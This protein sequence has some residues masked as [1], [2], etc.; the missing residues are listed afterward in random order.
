MFHIWFTKIF[1]VFRGKYLSWLTLLSASHCFAKLGCT[2]QDCLMKS[3]FWFGML[4]LAGCTAPR[5]MSFPY[6]PSGRGLNSTAAEMTPAIAGRYIVFTSDRQGRQDIYLYDTVNRGLL[7][8]PGLNALDMSEANPAISENGRY[9][10]FE[11]TRDGR[12]GIYLYDR[13]VRQLRNLTEAIKAQ[14]RLPTISAD[15]NVIAFEASSSGKW[16]IVLV[17]RFGQPIN[18]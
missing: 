10:V 18:R 2:P 9:I 7:D 1:L 6:D 5:L 3:I 17:N 4:F 11:G 8:L 16:A 12:S 14:V 15:G 13:D